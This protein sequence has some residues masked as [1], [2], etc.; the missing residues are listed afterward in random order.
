MSYK[1]GQGGPP[2]KET[3]KQSF[4]IKGKLP[5]LNEYISAERRNRYAAASMKKSHQIA[6]LMIV[7]AARLKRCRGSATLRYKFYEPNRRRDKDNI[8]AFAHK[9][10]QDALVQAGILDNDGWS[11]IDGFSDE[12]YLD[13][14]DPRI[15]VTVIS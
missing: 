9:V 12:F 4:V 1:G 13:P 11:Q 10:V 7:R 14:L 2:G 3:M 8:A 6:I 5:G 15:E